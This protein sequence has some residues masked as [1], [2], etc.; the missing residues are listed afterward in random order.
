MLCQFHF[1]FQL[2]MPGM[3]SRPSGSRPRPRLELPRP[4]RGRDVCQTARDETETRPSIVR[5]ET[6][7]RP[8]SGRDYIATHGLYGICTLGMCPNL[9]MSR[10]RTSAIFFFSIFTIAK[11]LQEVK[12]PLDHICF[13]TPNMVVPSSD[14]L[15]KY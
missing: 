12:W 7:T 15:R 6:E 2:L 5:D 1:N 4:R 13:N 3:G 14:T 11:Q 9:I 10:W 8:F